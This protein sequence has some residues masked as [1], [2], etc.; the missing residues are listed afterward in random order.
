MKEE[1]FENLV[2]GTTKSDRVIW[3]V[4]LV[5]GTREVLVKSSFT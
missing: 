1:I 5:I 2:G 3:I 4:L